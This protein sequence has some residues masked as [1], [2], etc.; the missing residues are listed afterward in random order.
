MVT[1]Q[2]GDL[3]TT[4]MVLWLSVDIVIVWWSCYLAIEQCG[5]LAIWRCGDRVHAGRW[6]I[7]LRVISSGLASLVLG[8]SVP[9]YVAVATVS[10]A[11]FP[12]ELVSTLL[13]ILL[14]ELV[15]FWVNFPGGTSVDFT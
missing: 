9:R 2:S 5:D 15:A 13:E 1:W 11:A 3:V 12:G 7:Y 14:G 10:T 4:C 8:P 6:H